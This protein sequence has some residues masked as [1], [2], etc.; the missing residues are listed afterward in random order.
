[1]FLHDISQLA[2]DSTVE[3]LQDEETGI[4]VVSQ[5]LAAKRQVSLP[6]LDLINGDA[7]QL[8]RAWINAQ[9]FL[10]ADNAI[11]PALFV[12]P[13]MTQDKHQ[14]VGRDFAGSIAVGID[15]ILSSEET[16]LPEELQKYANIY[17]D[18]LY[19]VFGIQAINKLQGSGILMGG[20]IKVSRSRAARSGENWL[21]ILSA[22]IP[23]FK[24]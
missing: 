3:L 5:A 17:T 14:I 8:W 20:G 6:E 15:L 18:A 4:V 11:F 19:T 24:N 21:Q 22:A 1:M 16:D 23:F 13:M 7:G 12:Y 9:D 10:A 2:E